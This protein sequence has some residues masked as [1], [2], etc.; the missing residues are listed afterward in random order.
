VSFDP[1]RDGDR[2]GFNGNLRSYY[3]LVP[4]GISEIHFYASQKYME[5]LEL[6]L[7]DA[8]GNEVQDLGFHPRPRDYQTHRV[9]G[10]G[11]RVLRIDGIHQAE[12]GFWLLNCPNLFA[13]HPQE[14]LRPADA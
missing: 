8:D 12:N 2:C 5:T 9:A 14:L 4:D 10:T 7:L 3:F 1:G 6:Y 11:R 13:I